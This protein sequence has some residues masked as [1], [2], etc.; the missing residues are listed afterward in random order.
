MISKSR[1]I[2]G[3]QCLKSLW[4]DSRNIPTTNPLDKSDKERADIRKELFKYCRLDTFAMYSI[5]KE[6]IKS[7]RT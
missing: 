1:F 7:A 2:L 6:L 4:L 3:Q 5:Y